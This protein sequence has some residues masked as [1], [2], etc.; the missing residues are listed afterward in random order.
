M[1]KWFEFEDDF[2]WVMMVGFRGLWRLHWAPTREDLV[3]D[4]LRGIK[5][6]DEMQIKIVVRR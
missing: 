4:F 3:Y 5:S 2:R 1:K 6:V